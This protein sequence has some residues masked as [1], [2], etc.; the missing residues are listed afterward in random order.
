[1]F[2]KF[3][4]ILYNNEY[5]LAVYDQNEMILL[6]SL[7]YTFKDMNDLIENMTD[8]QIKDCHKKC[9]NHEGVRI[10]DFKWCK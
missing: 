8:F 5:T 1:M 7:G 4:T 6:S 3:A 2:M 9:M 10:K